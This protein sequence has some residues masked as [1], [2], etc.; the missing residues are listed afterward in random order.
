VREVVTS[1]WPA[2]LRDRYAEVIETSAGRLMVPNVG[3]RV[4]GLNPRC[5]LAVAVVGGRDKRPSGERLGRV[6]RGS[7]RSIGFLLALTVSG[8]LNLYPA[9]LPPQNVL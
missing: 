4:T 9:K 6:G 5:F 8:F 1:L 7:G 2:L 3:R